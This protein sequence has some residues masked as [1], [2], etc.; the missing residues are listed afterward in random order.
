LQT[1][2][3]GVLTL[4]EKIGLDTEKIYR[5]L[6]PVIKSRRVWSGVV[7]E[8]EQSSGILTHRGV[9]DNELLKQAKELGVD[10]LN[11]ARII[12]SQF[13]GDHWALKIHQAGTFK[14]FRTK[15]L[16]DATGKKSII[17]GRK[18]RIGPQTIAISG[19]WKN[20]SFPLASTFLESTPENWLW[21]GR[22]RDELFHV[23][24]FFDPRKISGRSKIKE[25]YFQAIEESTL[26]KSCL[27]GSVLPNIAAVETT[28]YYYE[29]PAG[30][31][32]IKTGESSIGFDPIS[33]QGIQNAILNALQAA[34]VVNTLHTCS[35][36]TGAALDFYVSRQ[37]EALKRHLTLTRQAYSSA[38]P[39]QDQSF[40]KSRIPKTQTTPNV[41]QSELDRWDSET[42]IRVSSEISYKPVACIEGDQIV[43]KTGIHHPF[44][45]EPIVYLGEQDAAK[46][47][48]SVSGKI[49]MGRLIHSWTKSIPGEKAV[50]LLRLFRQFGILEE[51]R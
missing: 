37:Q 47:I 7:E 1:L 46:L 24:I 50:Q 44:L 27:Q 25:Q 14:I 20:T 10:I 12:D 39:W 35:S 49:S 11:P 41:V 32:F 13:I 22:S 21:G 28:P 9:F 26:F 45:D 34:I 51:V 42:E 15:F 38:L 16:V 29:N 4:L 8:N 18:I 23:T 30:L 31:H 36:N 2:T 43:L 33:S 40:W 17:R 3:P 19:T 5:C 48:D 6:T